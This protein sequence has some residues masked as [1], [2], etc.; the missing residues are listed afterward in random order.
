[1]DKWENDVYVEQDDALLEWWAFD[2]LCVPSQT[3][4]D[5][6]TYN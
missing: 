1:M 4:E 2:R 6:R 5:L 3:V